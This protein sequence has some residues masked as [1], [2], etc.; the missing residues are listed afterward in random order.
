MEYGELSYQILTIRGLD[1]ILNSLSAISF[2]LAYTYTL[3]G[4]RYQ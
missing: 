2:L 3:L 1:L 4:I